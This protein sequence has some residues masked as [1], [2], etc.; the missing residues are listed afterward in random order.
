M[1]KLN[2]DRA[3]VESIKT[4]LKEN[5]GFCPCQVEHTPDTKCLCKSFREQM[6]NRIE[7]ECHCGLY[8][9]SKE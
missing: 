6:H 2:K 3:L 4:K 7:G 1:V 8:V 5:G 9:F